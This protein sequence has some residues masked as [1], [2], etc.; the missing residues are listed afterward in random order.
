MFLRNPD[1]RSTQITPK[2]FASTSSTVATATVVIPAPP[3]AINASSATGMP[4]IR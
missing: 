3:A 1:T 4:T 2:M